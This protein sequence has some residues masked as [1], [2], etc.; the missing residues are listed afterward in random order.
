VK[1]IGV[2]TDL[3]KS[4]TDQSEHKHFLA[5]HNGLTIVARDIV[6]I[7]GKI[8]ITDY[9]VAN[10]CQSLQSLYNNQAI[11]T[12]ALILPVR[13]VKV[14]EDRSLAASIA[15]KTNNQNP[16]SLRDLSANDSTQPLIK[17]EFDKLYG[18]DSN[19]LIKQGAVPSSKQLTNEYAGQLL[20]SLYVGMPWS[21][22]QKYKLFGELGPQIF[23]YGINAP[24]IRLAQLTME[25]CDSSLSKCLQDKVKH[26]GLTRF[27]LL[28][29]VG[30]I[31]RRD[32]EG[33]A[34][35]HEPTPYLRTK[36]VDPE[37]GQ[38]EADLKLEIGK[39]GNCPEFRRK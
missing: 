27:A 30:E 13:I 19:Y 14:G 2:N 22:H 3:I 8:S 21:A 15:Y 25:V 23:K 20:L 31:L 18:F 38:L 12:N 33:Q 26:Y 39:L 29:L 9:S 10:G 35:L 34:L 11:L 32:K 7:K 16:I 17:A 36:Q 28:Y 6:L 5:Y 4:I 24:H 37:R 1:S